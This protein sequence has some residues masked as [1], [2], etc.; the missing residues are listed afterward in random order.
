MRSWHM[1]E[2]VGIRTIGIFVAVV[3]PLDSFPFAV[4]PRSTPRILQIV[5]ARSA[6]LVQAIPATRLWPR[7]KPTESS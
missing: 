5:N 6:K 4:L 3:G 2:C 1:C 7:H